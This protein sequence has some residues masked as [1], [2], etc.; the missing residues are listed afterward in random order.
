MYLNQIL[1]C[2]K[3]IK[4]ASKVSRMMVTDIKRIIRKARHCLYTA[5]ES[6]ERMERR[7]KDYRESIEALGFTRDD[8]EH[9][10]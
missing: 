10:D 8:K 5:A 2:V 6:G 3:E 1:E 7:L 9:S 4:P